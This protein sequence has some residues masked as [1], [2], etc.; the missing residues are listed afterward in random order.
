M[1]R[2]K[3]ER[4]IER[5]RD[6]GRLYLLAC[7]FIIGCLLSCRLD[8]NSCSPVTAETREM[9]DIKKEKKWLIPTRLCVLSD[10]SCLGD[11][12][13]FAVSYSCQQTFSG[14]EKVSGGKILW[15]GDTFFS[16]RLLYLTCVD[17]QSIL[18]HSET[19]EEGGDVQ[20]KR[21]RG[22]AAHT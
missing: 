6:D 14:V 3:K 11:T 1:I 17:S 4:N 19:S 2:D 15:Q 7:V 8:G 20:L 10:Y 18:S 12:K 9:L 13:R 16:R 21:R 22:S 5:W